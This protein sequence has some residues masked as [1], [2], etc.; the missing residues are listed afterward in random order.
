MICN[1]TQ[2]HNGHYG[3]E[4]IEEEIVA[5][6]D[7]A[8]KILFHEAFMLMCKKESFQEKAAWGIKY[9]EK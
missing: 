8:S 2:K 3:F 9:L 5:N 7:S 6:A 4:T 1:C